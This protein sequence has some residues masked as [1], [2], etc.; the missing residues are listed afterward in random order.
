M[1]HAIHVVATGVV[2]WLTAAMS[3]QGSNAAAADAEIVFDPPKAVVVRQRNGAPARGDLLRIDSEKLHLRALNGDE[4]QIKLER[5]RSVKTPDEAFEFWPEQET[6][7]EL[8]GRINTISGA[9]LNGKVPTSAARGDSTPPRQRGASRAA[10]KHEERAG[11]DSDA[12]DE[13]GRGPFGLQAPVTPQ[14]D[15]PALVVRTDS[16]RPAPARA[17]ETAESTDDTAS[18]AEPA[19]GTEILVCSNCEKDLP[20][21]F[22]SGGRCPHCDRVAIFDTGDA[23]PFAASQGSATGHDPFAATGAPAAAIPASAAAAVAATPAADDGGMAGIPL[24]GKIGIFAAFLV[25][26]WLI[27]QRR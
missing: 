20:A 12:R 27:L 13:D 26:G 11:N 5:V 2:Y 25:V 10:R 9:K 17:S 23:N 6:F 8:A 16:A 19:P 7:E 21:G 15:D 14:S 22:V 4:V 24:Y 18:D 1:R 3:L